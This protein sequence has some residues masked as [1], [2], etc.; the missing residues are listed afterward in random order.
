MTAPTPLS[1][2]RLAE[3]IETLAHEIGMAVPNKDATLNERAH[4]PVDLQVRH[5]DEILSALRELSS[6]RQ[7]IEQLEYARSWLLTD[8]AV[9]D[10]F[11]DSTDE[12]VRK[13]VT[14]HLRYLNDAIE[15][16]FSSPSGRAR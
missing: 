5:L 13:G 6:A 3:L 4:A 8:R 11:K 2:A 1:A 10:S 14:A 15:R 16:A 12:R 7:E 9:F